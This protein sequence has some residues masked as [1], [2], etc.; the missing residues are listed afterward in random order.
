MSVK[1][2]RDHRTF[3]MSNSLPQLRHIH[4]KNPQVPHTQLRCKT[5]PINILMI[6]SSPK[7]LHTHSFVT[8]S[9]WSSCAQLQCYLRSSFHCTEQTQFYDWCV[10]FFIYLHTCNLVSWGALSFSFCP[11]LYQYCHLLTVAMERMS[12][13][14]H[15]LTSRWQ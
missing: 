15:N 6:V 3:Q 11:T 8:L 9:K 12:L 5:P 1:N 10:V 2:E 4:Y 7:L 13:S 14:C